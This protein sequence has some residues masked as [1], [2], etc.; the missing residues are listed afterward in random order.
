MVTGVVVHRCL[1]DEARCGQKYGKA[2]DEYCRLVKWR[3]I[4]GIF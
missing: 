1:R 3:M 4:P 2:W